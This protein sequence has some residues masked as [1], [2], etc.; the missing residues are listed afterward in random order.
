MKVV[1]SFFGSMLLASAGCA[2][3]SHG[4]HGGTT[5]Y[6]ETSHSGAEAVSQSLTGH[7]SG[8]ADGDR[9]DDDHG[10]PLA[11]LQA[12]PALRRASAK[13][14]VLSQA[15]L[16]CATEALGLVDVHESVANA[17]QAL[18]V[19]KLRAAKLG[20]EAVVGVDF[21]HGDGR[22]ATHLSG[23]AVR[24]RDL[25]GGRSYDVVGD[26]N[27]SGEMGKEHEALQLL[28]AR[29]RELG[30]DLIVGVTYEHGDEGR[31]RSRIHGQAIRFRR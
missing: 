23:M 21:L 19:L 30:A 5:P 14:R 18:D 7:G 4:A 11:E 2:P 10:A 13:V 3:L 26:L 20:A 24:C 1:I 31:G 16:E 29:A 27:I 25:I 15:S 17:E 28:K 8:H 9:D 22:E 6:G 12:D